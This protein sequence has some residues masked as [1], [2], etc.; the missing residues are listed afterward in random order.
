MIFKR[1]GLF[2]FLF[3]VLVS[4][5]G[6]GQI[7]VDYQS[8]VAA[9]ETV[10]S[11]PVGIGQ[12]NLGPYTAFN[13]LWVF[14][15]DGANAVWRTK[16]AEEDGAWSDKQTVYSALHGN[17]FNVAF[18]GNYFHFVR[19]VND[20]VRYRRG[21]AFPDGSLEFDEEVTAWSDAVFN[22]DPRYLSIA[23]D[24]E[25]QPWITFQADDGTDR[26]PVVA[27][28]VATDGTWVDREDFPMDLQSEDTDGNHGRGNN[29]AVLED[30][31]VFFSWHDAVNTRM[32]ARVWEAGDMGEIENTGLS[33]SSTG[34]SVITLPSGTVFINSGTSLSR[35]NTNGTYTNISPFGME[36]TNFNSL[37]TDGTDIRIWDYSNGN[38]RFRESTDGGN[39]WSLVM[40]QWSA[41]DLVNFSA[42]Q[43][44]G[45]HGVH[46]SLLW[47]LGSSPFD[48]FA[49]VLG[50]V[51][52][53]QPPLLA[54]PQD[55]EEDVS[56][57]PT[58]TWE[59][60][61]VVGT[62]NVQLSDD[63]DFTSLL[64]DETGVADTLLEVSDLDYV[65]TYFWRVSVLSEGGTLSDWS[66]VWSFTT[67]PET[68]AVPVLTSPANEAVD[69]SI[70]P[71]LLWEASD[72][73][74]TY[75]VQLSPES[76][77][78]F[79]ILDTNDISET[80]F[81]VENLDYATEY[82]WRVRA[83][84]VAGVSDWS[85]AWSFTTFESPPDVPA[86]VSPANGATNIA[87]DTTF[88]WGASER[89][90]SYHLQIAADEGFTDLAVDMSGI[91]DTSSN[92]GGLDYS[93][94]YFWRVR[95]V[96]LA[97][98]SDWSSVRGFRTIIQAPETVTLF[99]P[100]N[101]AQNIAT[102]TLLVWF[103]ADRAESYHVQVSSESDFSD[104]VVDSMGVTSNQVALSDLLEETVYYWRVRGRNLNGF[105]NWSAVWNFKTKDVVS[106]DRLAGEIPTEFSL[107][108]NYPN[109]FNPATTIRFGLPSASN[110]YLEVYNMLGQR[111]ATLISGE[112]YEAGM[113]NVH[114]NAR[115]DIGRPVSSGLYI[116]RISA[117]DYVNVKK[118]MF[119]K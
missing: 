98:A 77:F 84:N 48:I 7:A 3:T 93:T 20:D 69:V 11:N 89:A 46:H 110:V 41:P 117:G 111:V 22:A 85:E 79:A 73:A 39:T 6:F 100:A 115:D 5:A 62:Y 27:A 81:S 10:S 75:R 105:G 104:L 42:T 76:D 106:V 83:E 92:V 94:D 116:Y 29:V 30:G 109:P 13:R 53:P 107:E 36:E 56:I 108:Q 34:S 43:G 15:S 71:E 54:S 86:L 99:S 21:E 28:S 82:Y 101:G 70:N 61:K 17:R 58:L 9:D 103:V 23:V 33:G 118:M 45:S 66:E 112:Y 40:N 87:V 14:Y 97:G 102:D 8:Q 65:S 12:G 19:V 91:A 38:I 25:G 64:V 119:T 44:K 74:E 59:P 26:K 68:P 57:S 1:M 95:A 88:V 37:S 60:A 47:S 90:Q 114:W 80:S 72:R 18:D 2:V 35:R 78:E 16:Q 63:P 67:M 31:K 49:G 51:P 55:G 32:S 50:S 24:N 4:A 96:N 113:Y 52:V